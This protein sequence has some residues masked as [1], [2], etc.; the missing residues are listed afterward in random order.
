[1]ARCTVQVKEKRIKRKRK[2]EREG[3]REVYYYSEIHCGLGRFRAGSDHTR[4]CIVL[5]FFYLR[6]IFSFLE[7]K[8]MALDIKTIKFAG[9]FT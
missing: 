4:L 1:M 7:V 5:D 6:F 9:S 8:T 2:K 3:R